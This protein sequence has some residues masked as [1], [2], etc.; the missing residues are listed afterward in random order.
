MMVNLFSS[1]IL[2]YLHTRTASLKSIDHL[3]EGRPNENRIGNVSL[4]QEGRSRK[5]QRQQIRVPS[6]ASMKLLLLL[7]LLGLTAASPLPDFDSFR[8]ATKGLL[9]PSE[10]IFGGVRAV[11]GQFPWQV[12][13]LLT[14]R[15]GG[16]FICG[17]SLLSTKH[18]LTAAHCTAKLVAPS[19]AMLGLVNIDSA[20]WTPGVQIKKVHA[21]TNLASYTGLGSLYDDISIITLDSEVTLSNYIKIVKIR[22]DDSQLIKQPKNTVTGFGTY[23]FVQ[24]NPLTSRDLL[25]TDVDHVPLSLCRQRW[26]Q[27]TGNRVSLWDKQICAGS[28]GKG[29]GPGDSGGPLLVSVGGEFVQIGLVS[30]GRDGGPEIMNQDIYPVVF[31]RLAP[32]CAFLTQ[33]TD[34]AFKCD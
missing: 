24:G 13:L 9:H 16:Q 28:R 20:R 17:G 5:P 23:T 25:Y 15:E 34:G 21:F 14:S 27:L 10:L 33:E 11:R 29:S 1:K 30:F 31:T 3:Q 12:Y 6:T 8:N 18:V 2:L 22:A 32:Y 7:S 4:P 26:A 19:Q